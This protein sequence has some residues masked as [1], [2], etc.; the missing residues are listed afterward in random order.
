[1]VNDNWVDLPNADQL[2]YIG[3]QPSHSLESS[4][5][6]TLNPGSYTVFV[7]GAG[8]STGNGMFEIYPQ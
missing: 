2:R 5:L 1:M 8:G 7:Y 4:L 6:I 3:F